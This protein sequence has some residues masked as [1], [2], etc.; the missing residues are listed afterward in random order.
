[1]GQASYVF[2]SNIS[3]FAVILKILKY[4]QINILNITAEYLEIST[5]YTKRKI[6]DKI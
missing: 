1:M 5:E 4:A 3:I 2:N 6:N